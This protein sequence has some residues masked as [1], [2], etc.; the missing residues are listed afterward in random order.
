[1]ELTENAPTATKAGCLGVL[2]YVGSKDARFEGLRTLKSAWRAWLPAQSEACQ[3]PPDLNQVSNQNRPKPVAPQH[4]A[5][6][7]IRAEG[8][9]HIRNLLGEP[10]EQDLA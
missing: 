4:E 9:V 6:I 10:V 1:M 5:T 2:R 3:P 8:S 7:Q